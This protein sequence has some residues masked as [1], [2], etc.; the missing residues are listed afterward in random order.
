MVEKVLGLDLEVAIF[1]VFFNRGC[2]PFFDLNPKRVGGSS[3]ASETVHNTVPE[4]EVGIP[5][6]ETP[7]VKIP[8]LIKVSRAVSMTLDDL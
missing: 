4:P 5:F 6:A 1:C 2:G 7:A 3:L 8:R